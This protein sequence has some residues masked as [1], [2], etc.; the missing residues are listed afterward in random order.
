MLEGIY[1]HII[2]YDLP[3]IILAVAGDVCQNSRFQDCQIRD[4]TFRIIM[5]FEHF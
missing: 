1:S 5:R 2:S 4:K 3:V